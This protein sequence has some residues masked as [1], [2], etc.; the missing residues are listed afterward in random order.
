MWNPLDKTLS[1]SCRKFLSFGILCRHDLKFFDVLDIKL[2][3]NRY[4]MKMWR[5]DAKDG[6]G[7]ICYDDP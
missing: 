4:I 5:R 3:P 6:S 7:I 2:I 1:Y